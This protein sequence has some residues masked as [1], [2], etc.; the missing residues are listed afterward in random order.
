MNKLAKI[1]SIAERVRAKCEKFAMSKRS[2]RYDFHSKED[3]NCMCA[4]ASYTL[5]LALKK[6]DIDCNMFFGQFDGMYHC[7]VETKRHI[8]DITATQ[9]GDDDFSKVFISP[10]LIDGNDNIEHYDGGEA[11]DPNKMTDWGNQR[12][13]LKLSQRILKV[14][15]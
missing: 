7:W 13:N 10:K 6:E 1:R 4:V 2:K 9:F 11:V 12:P 14:I 15:A 8:V 3:L 5:S